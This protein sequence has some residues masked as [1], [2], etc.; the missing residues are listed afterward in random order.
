MFHAPALFIPDGTTLGLDYFDILY[1]YHFACRVITH[2]LKR[3]HANIRT[4]VTRGGGVMRRIPR[5]PV[6]DRWSK[7]NRAPH[8]PL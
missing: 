2:P 4:N 7:L 3:E 6:F 8:N 1:L 5:N